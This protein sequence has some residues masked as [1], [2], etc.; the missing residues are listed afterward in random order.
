MGNPTE[1]EQTPQ[2]ERNSTSTGNNGSG[3]ILYVTRESGS[4]PPSYS[5]SQS[6]LGE[7]SSSS[8]NE[9][10]VLST[11][12]NNLNSMTQSPSCSQTEN[13]DM[14]DTA[15]QENGNN[16]ISVNAES[17]ATRSVSEEVMTTRILWPHS[18]SCTFACFSCIV[19]VYNINRFSLL[20]YLYKACFIVEFLILS[21][22]LGIPFLCLQMTLGQYIGSG[23]VDMW[24]ISPAFKGIGFA[25][26]YAYIVLGVYTAVP[27]AWLFVY[28][29]DSF[30][31]SNQKYLW[32]TCQGN[33]SRIYCVES[34]NQSSLDFVGWSVSSYFHGNVLHRNGY[35]NQMANLRFEIAFNLAVVWLIVFLVLSRGNQLYG[36]LVYALVAVPV[37]LMLLI[38]VRVMEQ[39]GSGISTL[40][41]TPWK[42]ILMDSTSW[43]LAAREV[44]LTWVLYG[45]LCQQMCS[46]NKI[47]SSIIK[48]V[49][50]VGVGTIFILILASLLFASCMR[51]ITDKDMTLIPSS[52]EK[53]ESVKFLLPTSKFQTTLTNVTPINFVIGECL[54]SSVKDPL[55]SGYQV[56]RFTTEIFPATI[57]LSGVSTVSSFWSISFFLMMI[58]FGL[59]QQVAL[60]SVVIDSVIALKPKI[61]KA[62]QTFLTIICCITGFLL[63]L[64]MTTNIGLLI[65]FFLDVCI[66]S[67][68]WVGSVFLVTII[69][70]LF[71][72]GRPYGTDQ[73]VCLISQQ[74]ATRVLV[75]PMLTFQWNVV[76]PVSY[77]ILSIAFVRSGNV[78]S[79]YPWQDND[80]GDTYWPL[81]LK[82]LAVII[83][84]LPLLIVIG[85][86][87]FQAFRYLKTFTGQTLNER[88]QQWCCPV[89]ATA[90][91]ALT[92]SQN[93]VVS[94]SPIGGAV[95]TTFE[96]DPPPKYTP[97]PSYSSAT[98]RML[99]QKLVRSRSLNEGKNRK[100]VN[101][102]F[103]SPVLPVTLETIYGETLPSNFSTPGSSLSSPT[104]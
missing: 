59:A 35:S 52:F 53:P 65:L 62:W 80:T 88:I 58:T 51:A 30:I 14:N 50:A 20:V 26:L 57:A 22:V 44:F 25:L 33:F 29:K 37:S 98:A 18:T 93:N 82:K 4:F 55:S 15:E 75:L 63:G 76:L 92:S 5:E 19:G 87:I 96:D 8:T 95:N 36:K 104:N 64:P 48:N 94:S 79:T 16:S 23:L 72:R 61:L 70:I 97:P 60:W 102:L 12:S 84:T 78:D 27:V 85:G 101:R 3:I 68:W 34:Q 86:C 67:L 54:F 71:I 31:T 40:F 32:E 81:W 69:V 56:L 77:L 38:T 99:I 83:Q 100:A 13:N 1:L 46:H 89:F 45:A 39:W 17:D 28:F 6:S 43:L 66:G 73:L 7:P 10:L 21:L 2:T 49:L 74:Q 42:S 90:N 41:D 24:Y 47:S 91:M 103:F 9:T 11:S